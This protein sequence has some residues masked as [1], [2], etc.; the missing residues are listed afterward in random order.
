MVIDTKISWDKKYNLYSAIIGLL[1]IANIIYWDSSSTSDDDQQEHTSFS[2][3][4]SRLSKEVAH[5][6]HYHNITKEE[7]P[8]VIRNLFHFFQEDTSK[9]TEVIN[10]AS[11]SA[12]LS[13]QL[14]EVDSLSLQGVLIDESGKYALVLHQGT[15]QHL[16][17]GD[18]VSDQEVITDISESYVLIKNT[19]TGNA[20]ELEIL[21]P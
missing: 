9:I 13:N 17:I 8:S 20:R 18:F 11:H 15:L 5:L 21:Q 12:K 16:K 1:V 7:N 19:D 4:E 14:P 6:I 10:N 2:E 3:S